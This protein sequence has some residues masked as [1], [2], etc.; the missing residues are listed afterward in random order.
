[1]NK[2]KINGG[3]GFFSCCSIRLFQIVDYINKYNLDPHVD[4][5]NQFIEYKPKFEKH[6]DISQHFFNFNNDIKIP[7]P[8]KITTATK[9]LQFSDYKLINFSQVKHVIDKYFYP[10]DKIINT[11]NFL[12][13][14]YNFNY[15]NLLTVY[16]RSTDKCIET[17]VPPFKEI[18]NKTTEILQKHPHLQILYIT[19]DNKTISEM[20]KKFKNVIIINEL[21]KYYK[22]GY[23]HAI[24][25]LSCV[26]IMSKSNS[27]I[28]TSGN[29]SNWMIFY[30]NHSN[31]IYQY[32]S[33]KKYIY[34][35]LNV[36]Y[37]EKKTNFWL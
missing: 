29:V 18:I 36:H 34:G 12:E 19:D 6:N 3:G 35:K 37:D 9:E 1:M 33:E 17:N 30:R 23:K 21:E 22:R 16:Y 20:Q 5:T 25:F 28:T 26:I 13:K 31:N 2:L 14:K 15:K 8:I 32:L 11:I 24:I 10:S 27:I 7:Y 4:S